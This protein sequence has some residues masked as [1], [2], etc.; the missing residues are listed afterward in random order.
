MN[1]F[2]QLTADRFGGDPYRA[3]VYIASLPKEEMESYA[4]QM[5]DRQLRILL[6]VIN[7]KA[8]SDM[9]EQ[10]RLAELGRDYVRNKRRKL[11]YS[12]EEFVSATENPYKMPMIRTFVLL[13]A[14][15]LIPLVLLFLAPGLSGSAT[16]N[17]TIACGAIL[18]CLASPAAEHVSNFFK[19]RRYKALYSRADL[20]E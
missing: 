5:K 16:Q 3:A 11:L 20:S 19:F 18:L 10:Q 8:L 7:H 17:V 15:L 1:K 14:A 12:R 2:D 4:K 6:E 13:A 9:T